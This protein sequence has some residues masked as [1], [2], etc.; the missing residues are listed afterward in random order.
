MLTVITLSS[1]ML[2]SLALCRFLVKNFVTNT[3]LNFKQSILCAIAFISC[4]YALGIVFH[5]TGFNFVELSYHA[6]NTLIRS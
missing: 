5:M 6:L 2:L 4:V 1:W 3:G